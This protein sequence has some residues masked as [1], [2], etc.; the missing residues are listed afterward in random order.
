MI[1]PSSPNRAN[2]LSLCFPEE[3]IDC[4][5]DVE[6]TRMIDGVF[7]HDD[8]R[9]EM[10]TTSM[11]QI[12][13]R[14]QPKSASPFNLC[15]V[16]A[17]EIVEEIQTVLAPELMEDVAVGDDLFEDTFRSIEEASNIVDLPF[18]FDILSGFISHPGDVYD[19]AS[20]DLSVF[21]YLPVSCDSICIFAFHSLTTQILD[22][23]DEITQPDSNKD[24]FDH[25]LDLID[26]RVSLATG[27]VETVDF[28]IE[29]QLKELKI[30]SPLSTDE[31]D[32]LIHLLI[33]Y[34]DVF[35]WSYEEMLGL[36]PSIV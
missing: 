12:T 16:S 14:V 15:R 13:E 2:F 5:V 20:M 17:I 1:V 36:D 10:D 19:S 26:E 9:D 24:S 4:G 7:P 29:D 3:T 30:G 34:L 18:S 32:R 8:Y 27:D 33:S 35:A 31:R 22:I 23:D 11:S 25:D 28:G 21:E 6:P